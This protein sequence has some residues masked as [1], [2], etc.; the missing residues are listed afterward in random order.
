MKDLQYKD[1]R[2]QIAVAKKDP[3]NDDLFKMVLNKGFDLCSVQNK[4]LVQKFGVSLSTVERWR[5]GKTSPHPMM[6][7][8]VYNYLWKVSIT[9]RKPEQ[10]S[11]P[12]PVSETTQQNNQ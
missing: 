2:K 7:G 11:L 9:N 12:V 5:T 10:L 1:Y 8:V 3:K 4:D 6:R